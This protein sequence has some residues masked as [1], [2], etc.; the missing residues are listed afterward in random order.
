MSDASVKLTAP[1]PHKVQQNIRGGRGG[2]IVHSK[3]K[4]W[5]SG[6]AS[7]S[8]SSSPLPEGRWERGR[9]GIT[10]RGRGGRSAHTTNGHVAHDTSDSVN[11]TEDEDGGVSNARAS[12]FAAHV[13]VDGVDV[14]E[15]WKEVGLLSKTT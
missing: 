14:E 12:R 2:S 5:V 15:V 11:A 10:I 4:T 13:V 6:R 8:T 1:V 3:N 7:S 9:G